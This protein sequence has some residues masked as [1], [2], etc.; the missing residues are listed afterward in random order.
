MTAYIITPNVYT[1]WP[2]RT[3][4][5]ALGAATPKVFR[6]GVLHVIEHPLLFV[7]TH[8]IPHSKGRFKSTIRNPRKSR[9]TFDKNVKFP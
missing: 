7:Y 1:P 2:A 6:M 3:E 8:S 9:S 5:D 4:D